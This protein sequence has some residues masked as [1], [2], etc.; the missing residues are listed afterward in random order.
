MDIVSN[1]HLNVDAYINGSVLVSTIVQ[2]AASTVGNYQCKD[3]PLVQVL[4]ISDCLQMLSSKEGVYICPV[5]NAQG[6]FW[7]NHVRVRR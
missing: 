4:R 1:C 5:P 7:G 3:S 6:P 2:E